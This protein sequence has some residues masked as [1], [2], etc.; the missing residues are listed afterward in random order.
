MI[1]IEYNGD[2]FISCSIGLEHPGSKLHICRDSWLCDWFCTISSSN[3][4]WS[5]GSRVVADVVGRSQCTIN[6]SLAFNLRLA[7]P[8]GT[9]IGGSA[10][11]ENIYIVGFRAT[12]QKSV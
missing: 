2:A 12:V 6:E 9:K 3:G 11:A 1:R 7:R 8:A 5:L 4:T 10:H